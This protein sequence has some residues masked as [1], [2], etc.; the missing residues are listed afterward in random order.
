MAK[1][2]SKKYFKKVELFLV[3]IKDFVREKLGRTMTEPP[4][5]YDIPE[6]NTMF[7]ECHFQDLE[8]VFKNGSEEWTAYRTVNGR[9]KKVILDFD[10]VL[11]QAALKAFA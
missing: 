9:I 1:V 2:A 3:P 4:I 10:M 7:L 5:I 6:N 11:A 8:F